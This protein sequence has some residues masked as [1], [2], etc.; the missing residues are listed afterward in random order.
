MHRSRKR[1]GTVY[2][3]DMVS[4]GISSKVV[5]TGEAGIMVPPSE[6]AFQHRSKVFRAALQVPQPLS[7]VVDASVSRAVCWN[8]LV[9]C[10]FSYTGN[11]ACNTVSAPNMTISRQILFLNGY[12]IS[13]KPDNQ[14]SSIQTEGVE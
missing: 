13:W 9:L 11:Q 8:L 14:V 10:K 1:G 7:E 12:A 6:L 5:Y 4:S 3:L 2:P